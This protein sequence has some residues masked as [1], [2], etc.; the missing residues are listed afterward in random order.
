HL[1][2]TYF[3]TQARDFITRTV[4][5][6]TTVFENVSRARLYGAEAAA[7]WQKNW[8]GVG[9]SYG[10][11]RGHDEATMNALGDLPGDQYIVKLMAYWND[12]FNFGTDAK[13][14]MKNDDVP[15]NLGGPVQPGTPGYYVEDFYVTYI[16]GKAQLNARV[17]NA[18]DRKY[19]MQNSALVE[20]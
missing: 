13:L 9:L 12:H 11:T 5:P 1:D 2:A 7:L 3:Q 10:Q 18:F 17:A 19:V 15:A 8:W 14:V 4:G 16:Y 20:K 6:T